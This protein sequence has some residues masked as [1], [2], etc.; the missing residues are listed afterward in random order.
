MPC[1]TDLESNKTKDLSD[2]RL[3]K[4]TKTSRIKI[5]QKLMKENS[6]PASCAFFKAWS[7]QWLRRRSRDNV[8]WNNLKLGGRRKYD[9]NLLQSWRK[10]SSNSTYPSHIGSRIRR[11]PQYITPWL[12]TIKFQ[13]LE[14]N[15]HRLYSPVNILIFVKPN[16]KLHFFGL[17]LVLFALWSL[18]YPHPKSRQPLWISTVLEMCVNLLWSFI[19][20][21]KISL[22][23]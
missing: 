3:R 6:N 8:V 1:I 2:P 22:T 12:I 23:T 20:L 7:P 21:D 13:H 9:E 15:L 4:T 19:S 11:S 5:C 14:T 10:I 16:S 17:Y 18:I